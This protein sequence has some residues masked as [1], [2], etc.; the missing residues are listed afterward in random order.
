MCKD[1]ISCC[2]ALHLT[3]TVKRVITR[4]SALPSKIDFSDMAIGREKVI[5]ATKVFRIVQIIENQEPSLAPA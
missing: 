2:N 5:D 1:F 3:R 4:D